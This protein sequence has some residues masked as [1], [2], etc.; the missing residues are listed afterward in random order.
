MAAYNPAVVKRPDFPIP[1]F[2]LPN[3]V[4]FPGTELRLHIFEPR[5]R[6][7]VRDVLELEPRRRWIGMMLLRPGW[8]PGESLP[9]VFD[10][11]TAGRLVSFEPLADGRC[12]ILLR[13]DFRFE[14][15][16]EVSSDPY[17]RALVIPVAEVEPE[18]GDPTA[19]A[20]RAELV[21]LSA[22]LKRDMGDR[23]PFDHEE[24]GELARA[25]RLSQVV[26]RLAADLDVPILRKQML[27][28]EDLEERG[29]SVLRILRSRRRV[30]DLLRPYRHLS[31]AAEHN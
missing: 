24:L 5:Y 17:R 8:R 23:F 11:G 31:A 3:V 18:S 29:A 7:M 21:R 20:L 22:S 13:G 9:A 15:D 10:A 25:Q 27:L 28:G 30:L 4:H 14:L 26:N 1:L 6:Q 19:L 16:R 12:D 2:P